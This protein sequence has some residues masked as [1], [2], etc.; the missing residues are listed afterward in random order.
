VQVTVWPVRTDD[1]EQT[2]AVVV[3]LEDTVT[4]LLVP[5]LP[6]CAVSLGAYVPL[7]ITVPELV[8]L[9][10]TEQLETEA[11]TAASA[12]GLPVNEPEALPVLLKATVPA[13]ALGVPAA[14]VSLT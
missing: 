1:G 13:G 4:M 14:D 3:V 2:T 9:N 5:M 11:L 8:G 6:L 7:A 10:D 12:H